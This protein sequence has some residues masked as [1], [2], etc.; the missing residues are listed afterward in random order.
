MRTSAM[1]G[2]MPIGLSRD[3]QAKLAPGMGLSKPPWS[4]PT[5]VLFRL[6]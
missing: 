1:D 2:S 5:Q 6:G 3:G 4:Q